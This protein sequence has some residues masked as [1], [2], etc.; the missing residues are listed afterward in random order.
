VSQAPNNKSPDA[1]LIAAQSRL[2]RLTALAQKELE[3]GALNAISVTIAA[4]LSRQLGAPP[5]S[6]CEDLTA[7]VESE[8]LD[9]WTVRYRKAVWHQA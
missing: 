5:L 2:Q 9:D 1:K 8:R 6:F 7:E 4:H 3:A